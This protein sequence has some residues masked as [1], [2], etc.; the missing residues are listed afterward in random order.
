LAALD[1]AGY[2]DC[3][4]F[5]DDSYADR[6]AAALLRTLQRQWDRRA[7]ADS[8]DYTWEGAAAA[9]IAALQPLV[10]RG[11]GQGG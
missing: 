8:V 4:A 3:G 9:V 7:I 2:R 1:C 11:G 5:D 10:A 6:L